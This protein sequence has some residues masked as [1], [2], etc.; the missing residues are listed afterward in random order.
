M[1]NL[2]YHVG[3]CQ[4][5]VSFAVGTHLVSI[6]LNFV[7]VQKTTCAARIKSQKKREKRKRS[8]KKRKK[9]RN[10]QRNNLLLRVRGQ[11]ESPEAEASSV[12]QLHRIQSLTTKQPRPKTKPKSKSKRGALEEADD[13]QNPWKKRARRVTKRQQ[14]IRRIRSQTKR[15]KH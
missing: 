11:R 10:Q 8:P 3:E 15:P 9:R 6:K 4:A 2:K 5:T 14:R 13:G 12:L 1:H 7:T